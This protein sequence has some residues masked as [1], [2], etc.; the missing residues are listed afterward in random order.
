MRL[1]FIPFNYT[2]VPKE[3]FIWRGKKWM[4]DWKKKKDFYVEIL[5]SEGVSG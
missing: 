4:S 1:I 3:A 5:W 2:P